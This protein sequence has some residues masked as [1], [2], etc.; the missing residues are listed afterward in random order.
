MPLFNIFSN[1]LNDFV[2]N[3]NN[4][5][6]ISRCQKENTT[7]SQLLAKKRNIVA[8]Y[9]QI[10]EETIRKNRIISYFEIK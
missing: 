9:S 3:F 5:D 10:E 6:V 8:N 2:N 7:N 1:K 4:K